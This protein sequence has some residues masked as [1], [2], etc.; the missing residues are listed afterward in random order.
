MRIWAVIAALFLVWVAGAAP[1]QAKV[2]ISVDLAKQTMRVEN[3][4][5]ETYTWPISSAR[6]GFVTP[7][8]TY[9]PQR[10]ATMHYSRKYH[11]SPMPHSIFFHAGWAIHGTNEARALG[12][13]ASH[14]CVR[15]SKEN[16]AKLFAMVKAEGA[17][18]RIDGTPPHG[19]MIAS[20]AK[21]K[22][23]AVKIASAKRK[24]GPVA[25]GYAPVGRSA[26]PLNV[27]AKD[28]AHWT[29]R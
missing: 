20:N 13:P 22:S 29:L 2:N 28:P 4:T 9:A 23:K 5:G 26:P 18:I 19:T 17:V 15:L 12:R 25:L 7:R 1:A 16:A 24:V 3:G 8:G 10:L 27:W 21:A 6:K 11:M 14:G